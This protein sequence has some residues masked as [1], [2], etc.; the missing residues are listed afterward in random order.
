MENG[1]AEIVNARVHNLPGRPKGGANLLV[2]L[3]DSYRFLVFLTQ[4]RTPHIENPFLPL[5]FFMKLILIGHI[6]QI[7]RHK[8]AFVVMKDGVSRDIFVRF[9]LFRN[10]VG[11]LALGRRHDGV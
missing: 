2:A 9:C 4:S 3:V 7:F 10:R 8:E 5:D 6:G 1:P 11:F